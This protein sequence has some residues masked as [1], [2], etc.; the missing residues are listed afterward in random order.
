M[1][2]RAGGWWDNKVSL[3]QVRDEDLMPLADAFEQAGEG[4]SLEVVRAV[5]M[6]CF[7]RGG[8]VRG[9]PWQACYVRM[10]ALA[11]HCCRSLILERS[12]AEFAR[13]RG[14]R[15]S[16][17]AMQVI[18]VRRLLAGE[19]PRQMRLGLPIAGPPQAMPREGSAKSSGSLVSRASETD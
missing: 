19:H 13:A 9:D 18:E 8:Q 15:K 12:L 6:V 4:R 10:C 17:L 1:K 16:T 5:F 7:R 14:L 11:W 3:D 2:A